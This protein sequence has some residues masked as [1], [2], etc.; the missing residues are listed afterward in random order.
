MPKDTRSKQQALRAKMSQHQTDVTDLRAGFN[1]MR[2]T[3][4]P[5]REFEQQ[6][7]GEQRRLL[8]C[9]VERAS[10]KD[11]RLDRPS[12]NRSEITVP[13]SRPGTLQCNKRRGG[14]ASQEI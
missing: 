1:M 7:A 9:G 4:S 2:L 10:W 6:P 3:A 5:C 11:G 13:I 14:S 8:D 12:T